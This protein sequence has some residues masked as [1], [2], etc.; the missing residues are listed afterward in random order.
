MSSRNGA[1]RLDVLTIGRCGVDVYP[2]Q[3]GVGLED[4]ETFGKFL[5]G[6]PTNVTVAAARLGHT[7]ATVT[8]VGDDPFGRY[9]RR[10]MRRLGVDD[11]YVVVVPELLPK[12]DHWFEAFQW[13]HRTLAYTLLVLVVLHILAALKHRFFDSNRENDVL[14]RML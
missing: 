11:R 5:G 8:G 6:S 12:N 3:T 1:H 4:V 2:L 10:E 14:R 13:L 9:V 7:A